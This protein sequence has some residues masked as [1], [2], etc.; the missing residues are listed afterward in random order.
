MKLLAFSILLLV[1]GGFGVMFAVIVFHLKRYAIPGDKMPIILR[2]FIIGSAVFAL[3]TAAVFLIVPWDTIE[4][5][6][7]SL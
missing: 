5:V 7:P 1:F 4:F 6:L 3:L 2:T